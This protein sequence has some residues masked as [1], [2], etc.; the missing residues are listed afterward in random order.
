[1]GD[2]AS[3]LEIDFVHYLRFLF[4]G[5]SPVVIYAAAKSA[6]Y[7]MIRALAADWSPRCVGEWECGR[8]DQGEYVAQYR[9]AMRRRSTGFL[10]RTPMANSHAQ[11]ILA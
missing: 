8:L 7:S 5:T 4:M 10:S 3:W 9:R 6:Y 2:A 1:L 11:R